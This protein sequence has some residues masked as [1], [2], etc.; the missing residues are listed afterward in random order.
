MEGARKFYDSRED[1]EL[2][3]EQKAME[4][5]NEGTSILA[6]SADQERQA[7]R[8]FRLLKERGAKVDLVEVVIMV[9][10]LELVQLIQTSQQ[11]LPVV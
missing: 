5:K 2:F 8:A 9:V 1:A 10:T 7:V 11:V 4:R 3:A 6:L